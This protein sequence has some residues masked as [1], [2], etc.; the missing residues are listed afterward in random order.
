MST[1]TSKFCLTSTETSK[2]ISNGGGGGGGR[3]YTYR[4]TVTTRMTPALKMGQNHKTVSTNH[5]L[6]EENGEPKWNRDVAL[7]VVIS[8]SLAKPARKS[9]RRP[10]DNSWKGAGL[11][12]GLFLAGSNLSG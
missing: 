5:N 1:E 10:R 12:M 3:L 9:F 6:S 2:F 4:Y 7:D 11:W 8:T